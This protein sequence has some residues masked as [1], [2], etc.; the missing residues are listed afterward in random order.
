[1]NQD[2]A[3]QHD[4]DIRGGC[5]NFWRMLET[6]RWSKMDGLTWYK[7]KLINQVLKEDIHEWVVWID[8][9]AAVIHRDKSIQG[10]L[11]QLGVT[12][13]QDLVI[14][15][16]LTANCFVNA[17]VILIR[18]TDFS[19]R[20]FEE[21]WS[22]FENMDDEKVNKKF[23]EQSAIERK[24]NKL[25]PGFLNHTART[26]AWHSEGKVAF[27]KV[28]ICDNHYINTN[29]L[30]KCNFIFH[31]CGKTPEKELYAAMG[32]AGDPSFESKWFFLSKS[33]S[34]KRNMLL[35]HSLASSTIDSWVYPYADLS[36]V[37]QLFDRASLERF[38]EKL[39]SKVGT[40]ESLTLNF[41][42]GVDIAKILER[43][44]HFL[45]SIQVVGCEGLDKASV[46]N[47]LLHLRNC[48]KRKLEYVD[49]SRSFKC[50]K[51]LQGLKEFLVNH[52]FQVIERNHPQGRWLRAEV[53]HF[54]TL[55]VVL[56]PWETANKVV[57]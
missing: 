17:G 20:F 11:Q 38:I 56:S 50:P 10:I 16:D 21:I 55:H 7:I 22:E 54:G 23:H 57:A 51:E 25:Y 34:E 41:I 42:H 18:N 19:K 47:A 49:L 37:E 2:Y 43:V 13:S 33:C 9:D 39:C 27:E 1:M 40:L 4:Y 48:G 52:G 45:F 6:V 28:L 15:K 26:G 30:E 3:C 53:Y 8:A 44:Y 32:L 46:E 35:E 14:A 5:L 36:C 31:A 12:F 24:I 29:K